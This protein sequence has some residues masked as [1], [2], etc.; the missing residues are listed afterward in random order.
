MSI[1]ILARLGS[2]KAISPTY[3]TLIKRALITIESVSLLVV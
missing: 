3:N 1:I 2:N